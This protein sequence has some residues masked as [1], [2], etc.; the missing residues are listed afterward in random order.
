MELIAILPILFLLFAV[1]AFVIAI[2]LTRLIGKFH[3]HQNWIF[4]VLAPL[5]ILSLPLVGFVFGMLTGQFAAWVEHQSW[6]AASEK[7]KW[8]YSFS[9]PGWPGG[10]IAQS[11]WDLEYEDSAW[12]YRYKI[13]NCNGCFWAGVSLAAIPMICAFY[14]GGILSAFSETSKNPSTQTDSARIDDA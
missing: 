5:A 8:F 1:P 9:V 10:L 12:D 11:L 14:P 6:Q 3:I 13:A 7:W 2:V 4:R